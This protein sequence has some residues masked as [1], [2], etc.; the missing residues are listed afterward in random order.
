MAFTTG[1]KQILPCTRTMANYTKKD[2]VNGSMN[3]KEKYKT[4]MIFRSKKYPWADIL[5]DYVTYNRL[6]ESSYEFNIFS[7]ICLQRA[8]GIEFDKFICRRK[9][10]DYNPEENGRMDFRNKTTFPFPS[11]GEA[12]PKSMDA[13]IKKYE[14][15]YVGMSDKEITIYQD[16]KAEYSSGFKD[17]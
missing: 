17:K 9:G 1:G 11:F 7:A 4:G 10:Y 3:Y 13:Y 6:A 2:M 14:L 5:I 12:K 16:N 8:N 15:E